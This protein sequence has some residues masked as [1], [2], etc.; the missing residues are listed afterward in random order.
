MLVTPR[1]YGLS[2]ISDNGLRHDIHSDLSF[3]RGWKY[4]ARDYR[5]STEML[6]LHQSG[7][8]RIGEVVR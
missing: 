6:L 1:L 2:Q 7:T 5:E 4:S 8:V 3:V